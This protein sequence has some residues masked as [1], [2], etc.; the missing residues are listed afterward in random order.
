MIDKKNIRMLN[1]IEGKVV[2]FDQNKHQY[3]EN[4]MHAKNSSD[5]RFRLFL[6]SFAGPE[7]QHGINGRQSPVY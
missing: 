3:L 6:F 1:D 4:S 2:Y 7:H 5:S